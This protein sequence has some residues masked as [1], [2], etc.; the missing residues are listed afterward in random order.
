MKNFDQQKEISKYDVIAVIEKKHFL[1]SKLPLIGVS[2]FPEKHQKPFLD[3]YAQIRMSVR[4][5]MRVLE[6]GAGTGRHSFPVLEQKAHLVALDISRESLALLDLKYSHKVEC[7]IG[8]IADLPFPE[9]A[10]DCVIS[11]GSLSYGEPMEVLTEV[12]RVLK[13]G[14]SLIFLDS[15]NHNYV[16]RLNRF[17]H[18]LRGKRTR[19]TLKYMPR[20]STLKEYQKHF[21]ENKCTQYGSFLFLE[22]PLDVIVTKKMKIRIKMKFQKS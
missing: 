19:S 14:G 11:A 2:D 5:G 17:I 12:L 15:L 6:L 18:F 20:L 16:Y 7:V 9:N 3:Y 1:Q 22:G 10:F 4:E 8:D 13:P 21:E